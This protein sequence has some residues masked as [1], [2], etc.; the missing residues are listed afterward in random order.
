MFGCRVIH[1]YKSQKCIIQRTTAQNTHT[2]SYLNKHTRFD[3]AHHSMCTCSA[4]QYI[5]SVGCAALPARVGN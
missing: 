1:P 5:G 4:A 3:P 2:D